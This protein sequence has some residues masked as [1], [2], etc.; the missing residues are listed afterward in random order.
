[1]N[2]LY[3]KY[4]KPTLIS[5]NK[6]DNDVLLKTDNFE[7]LPV[8]LRIKDELGSGISGIVRLGLLKVDQHESIHVAV[9]MLK[10][11]CFKQNSFTKFKK[12]LN[13]FFNRLFEFRRN[14][15][16]SPRNFHHEIRWD[17]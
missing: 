7:I 8:Q 9:K 13:N 6:I 10:G 2:P 12:I 3:K 11:N 14:K 16:F 15:K 5:D 1:M 17:S 4:L